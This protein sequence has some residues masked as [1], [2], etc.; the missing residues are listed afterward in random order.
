MGPIQTTNP[1]FVFA[2]FRNVL[3]RGK[4]SASHSFTRVHRLNGL[5]DMDCLSDCVSSPV[6]NPHR[7]LVVRA[8]PDEG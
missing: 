8:C 7:G 2:P 1:F 6:L 4:A 5:P 3:K